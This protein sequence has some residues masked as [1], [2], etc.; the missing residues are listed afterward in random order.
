MSQSDKNFIKGLIVFFLFT[1][2]DSISL[3]QNNAEIICSYGLKGER[4]G[5]PKPF[6]GPGIKERRLKDRTEKPILHGVDS[7]SFAT[8]HLI[9]R[10]MALCF[11]LEILTLLAAQPAIPLEYLTGILEFICCPHKNR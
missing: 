4:S 10:F 1:T 7:V 5:L 2:S 8:Q 6:T 3:S 11:Y 9:Q